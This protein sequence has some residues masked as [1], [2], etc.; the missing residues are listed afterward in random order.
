MQWIGFHD[1]QSAIQHIEVCVSNG[2]LLC[3]VH[4]PT[5]VFHGYD[6]VLTGLTLTP[7]V[8]YTVAVQAC[9]YVQMCS[10]FVEKDFKVDNTPPVVMTS[11]HLT[12]YSALKP[13][14][15]LDRSYVSVA[16]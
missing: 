14:T 11:L 6:V 8:N 2:E 5:R 16:W 15:Q 3:N 13:N 7:N 1:G 12:T 4:G 9:N 10:Q